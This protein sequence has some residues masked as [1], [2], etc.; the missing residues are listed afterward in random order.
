MGRLATGERTVSFIPLDD[1]AATLSHRL[2]L[3]VRDRAP[4]NGHARPLVEPLV[5]ARVDQPL[6]EPGALPAPLAS[7]AIPGSETFTVR[8]TDLDVLTVQNIWGEV[9]VARNKVL[10]PGSETN[11]KFVYNLHDARMPTAAVPLIEY[12]EAFDM[13]AGTNGDRPLFDWIVGFFEALL[14]QYSVLD[15]D[16][17]ETIAVKYGITVDALAPQLADVNGLLAVGVDLDVAGYGAYTTKLGD[18]LTSIAAATRVTVG[19]V[20][21]AGASVRDL[22]VAGTVINPVASCSR[23]IRVAVFYAFTVVEGITSA[24][25]DPQQLRARVPAYLRTTCLF[26]TAVDLAKGGL[27]DRLASAL[28][29]WPPDQQ[30]PTSVGMWVFDVSL[31][32]TFTTSAAH[33]TIAT[34]SDASGD[35]GASTNAPGTTQLPPLLHMTTVFLERSR[36]TAPT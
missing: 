1:A 23:Y 6:G 29:S 18:T 31:Y 19:A 14:L 35:V 28:E 27:C 36:V 21:A 10:I 26:D 2:T 15:G 5:F 24:A 13:T 25:T 17:L 11:P 9:S 16:T 4:T 30:L 8:V 20:A 12:T 32:S 34:K 7:E 3:D 33:C 22:L